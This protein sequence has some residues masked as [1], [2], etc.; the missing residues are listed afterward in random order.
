MILLLTTLSLQKAPAQSSQ[1]SSLG[2]QT[3]ADVRKF[4]I[5]K[6]A[7]VEVKL[8]DKSKLKGFISAVEDDSFTITNA[9]TG[10]T[11]TFAYAEVTQ[12]RKQSSG[13]S[14]KTWLIIAGAAAAA[15]IAGVV[16]KPALCDGGAQ[17]RFP[18]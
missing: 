4:G 13:L 5:G 8:Q 11:R 17:T 16:V 12:V 15:I 7:K 18:C 10:E 2:Q 9:K 6:E 1:S 3:R 14:S